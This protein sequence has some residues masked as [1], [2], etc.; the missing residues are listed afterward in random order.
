MQTGDGDMMS[1]T[2]LI[3]LHLLALI[4][5]TLPLGGGRKRQVNA[6]RGSARCRTQ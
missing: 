1:R 2:F 5:M 6:G 3:V 4:R